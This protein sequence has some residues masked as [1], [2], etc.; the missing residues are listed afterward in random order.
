M[1][2]REIR[3]RI[4]VIYEQIVRIFNDLAFDKRIAEMKEL[5]DIVQKLFLFWEKFEQAEEECEDDKEEVE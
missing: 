5:N 4:D 2:D 3:V 1:T